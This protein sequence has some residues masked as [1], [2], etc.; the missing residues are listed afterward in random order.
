MDIW[1]QRR[2]DS[3]KVK[4]SIQPVEQR[5]LVGRRGDQVRCELLDEIQCRLLEGLLSGRCLGD[6]CGDLTDMVPEGE[7]LP[8]A[9]WFS[10]W[11]QDGFVTS[12]EFSKKII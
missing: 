4:I 6:D 7:N 3:S 2:E 10:R 11:V 5:I 8:I 12:C 1:R 9:S